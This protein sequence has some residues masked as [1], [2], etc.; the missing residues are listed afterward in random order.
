M[1][2]RKGDSRRV[3]CVVAMLLLFS[4]PASAQN[5]SSQS[6]SQNTTDPQQQ[7]PTT[8]F[9]VTVVGTTPL[10]DV[11]IPVE[12]IAAPVQTLTGRDIDDSG[13]LDLANYLNQRL[14]GVHINEVQNNPFQPDVNYRGYTA[15]PLLGTPQGLS[16]YMDGV[17]L[18]QPF[19]DV[20]SWDLIP[21]MAIFS[22]ALMPGSNPLFGLNTLGGALSIQTKDGRNSPGTTLQAVYGSDSRRYLEFE[23]GGRHMTNGV[24]WYVAGNLFAEDGWRDDSP[25]DV[26]QLF[27]KL[28]WRKSRGDVFV[29]LAYADNELTGNGLQEISFLDRDYASVYTKPDETDNRSTLLTVTTH[30]TLNDRLTFSGNAYFRDIGTATF[31]GDINEESLDQSLYQPTAAEQA[32]LLAAG[33]ITAPVIGADA[34]N[35]PFPY[36]R[37]VANVL[38]VDEPSEKCNGL[39]NTTETSQRNGGVNGQLTHRR[40]MKGSE[41]LFVVGGAFDR[42]SIGFIQATELGYLNPDR[43][44]TGVGA[45]RRASGRERRRFR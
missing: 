7:P 45:R 32:A 9:T 3:P 41:N 17:R 39:I 11:T 27:G 20:V 19:G 4:V 15:S 10:V 5:A 2:F 12:E 1:R 35:T 14:N 42:S 21:R 36:L 29:T 30:R 13:A 28:A 44:V 24:D 6:A 37:C 34:S 25:S 26:R 22:G 23:H 16:V 31:N 40:T 18:N 8:T 33:Y 38:L 43:G